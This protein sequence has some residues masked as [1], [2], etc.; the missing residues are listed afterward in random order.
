[1][2]LTTI[3]KEDQ[4]GMIGSFWIMLQM[5]EGQAEN[6]LDKHFVDKYYE[7]WNRVTDD[8]KVAR[9]NRKPALET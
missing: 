2:Q 9:W 8:N 5:L 7:Q 3:K 4:E 1:M 6:N